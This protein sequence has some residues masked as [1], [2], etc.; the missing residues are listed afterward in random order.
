MVHGGLVLL[1][2][3][4]NI[5]WKRQDVIFV[6]DPEEDKWRKETPDPPGCGPGAMAE[7]KFYTKTA[8]PAN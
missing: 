7:L 5:Y 4:G 1:T 3:P 8:V 6:Y 2:Y